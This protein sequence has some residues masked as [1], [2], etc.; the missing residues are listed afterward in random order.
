MQ[1][2][3]RQTKLPESSIEAGYYFRKR[4]FESLNDTFVI[5]IDIALVWRKEDLRIEK[6]NVIAWSGPI[7]YPEVD[8]DEK[9]SFRP[10]AYSKTPGS[11]S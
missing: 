3:E 1:K 5:V 2:T 6:D 8:E 7:P 10:V 11:E 9:L 4:K